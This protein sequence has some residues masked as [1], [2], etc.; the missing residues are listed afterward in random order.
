MFA[1]W[2]TLMLLGMALVCCVAVGASIWADLRDTSI[3]RAEA[4]AE[5]ERARAQQLAA[6]AEVEAAKADRL[7]AEGEKAESWADADVHRELGRAASRAVDRQGR[8]LSWYVVSGSLIGGWRLLV[9]GGLGG[10]AVALGGLLGLVWL[11]G[12]GVL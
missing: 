11:H 1:R 5:T 10:A 12:R 3:R 6:Q 4:E 8:L 9:L 7:R 2:L